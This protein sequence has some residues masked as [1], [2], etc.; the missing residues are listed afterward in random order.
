MNLKVTKMDKIK[1]E[2]D[3]KFVELG[4]DGYEIHKCTKCGEITIPEAM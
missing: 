4:E 2:H 1:C 3:W